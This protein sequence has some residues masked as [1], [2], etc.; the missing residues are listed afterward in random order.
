MAKEKFLRAIKIAETDFYEYMTNQKF[1]FRDYDDCYVITQIIPYLIARAYN[2]KCKNE[3]ISHISMHVYSQNPLKFMVRYG[4]LT[5]YQELQT[6]FPNATLTCKLLPVTFTNFL[7]VL[8]SYDRTMYRC[9]YDVRA[10]KIIYSQDF[11]ES[12]INSHFKIVNFSKKEYEFYQILANMWFSATVVPFIEIPKREKLEFTR[13]AIINVDNIRS[14]IGN[15]CETIHYDNN[16]EYLCHKCVSNVENILLTTGK[17][18]QYGVTVIGVDNS[19]GNLLAKGIYDLNP[20]YVIVTSALE[21]NYNPCEF[22]SSQYADN[23]LNKHV[24]YNGSRIER[25]LYRDDILLSDVIIYADCVDNNENSIKLSQFIL[26][27]K[28]FIE[29]RKRSY[30]V[31]QQCILVWVNYCNRSH[32]PEYDSI[33]TSYKYILRYL[34]KELAAV[35][36]KIVIYDIGRVTLRDASRGGNNENYTLACKLLLWL[37][38]KQGTSDANLYMNERLEFPLLCDEFSFFQ[39]V[40][41]VLKRKAPTSE[42]LRNTFHPSIV[43][44]REDDEWDWRSRWKI[45]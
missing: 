26:F 22:I 34:S 44:N 28:N 25:F 37:I 2:E 11:E 1:Q 36:V 32:N 31:I 23:N 8:L 27:L 35:N 10:K 12:V 33:K 24:Q 16:C 38:T 42:Q 18:T 3:N 17:F 39:L 7:T 13:F 15:N 41:D 5:D 19:I 6:L 43:L 45:E 4:D 29:E 14:C 20:K 21:S 30:G 9:G 40:Q